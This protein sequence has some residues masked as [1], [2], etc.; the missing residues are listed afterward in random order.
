[1]NQPAN[2][3]SDH[4]KNVLHGFFLS[5]GTTIAEPHTILPLIISHFGGGAILI[6]FFSS[7]LR[8]GAILVQLYAAFHAQTYPRMLPYMRRVMTAR[9]FS[10][11]FI[12]IAILMFGET[13]PVLTLWCIGI[14]LFIFSFSAGFGAIYFRE[15]IAKL[16]THKFRG[17]TMSTRQ[18][19]SAFAAII[20]GTV[21]GYILANFEAPFSFGILF[22]ASAFLMGF[23][24]MAIGSVAEPIKQKVAVKEKSFKLFLKNAYAT[25]Q[26]DS[27]LKVQVFTF[28][29][30]Y[31]YLFS[32][33]FIIVDAQTKIEL[34]GASIGLLITAQMV[35]SMLSNILWGKLSS[36]GLNRLISQITIGTTI[37]AIVLAFFSSHLYGYMFLFFLVGTAMDG[38]RIASGNLLL[39]LAPEQ[40]R[41]VYTALQT[42]IVSLGMF[43]SIFGGVLLSISNYTILYSFTIICLVLAFILSFKLKDE[44]E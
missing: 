37:F 24:Y 7:L 11:L 41:P 22:V 13:S 39:I 12:G 26:S 32:L 28:L 17:K 33:P 19:W 9:F 16:F 14:G 2:K 21:A 25:L 15:I 5:I 30:A 8:G 27:Q 38:N 6:G 31:S 23:G 35:G 1:M 43:F 4:I 44:K 36:K 42:N 34:T 10:W 40:K 20:S 18:F 29:L 3:K